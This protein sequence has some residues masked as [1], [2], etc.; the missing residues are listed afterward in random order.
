MTGGNISGDRQSLAVKPMAATL[1]SWSEYCAPVIWP[2]ARARESAS[3]GAL[4][5]SDRSFAAAA[6]PAN[7]STAIASKASSN[8]RE[9]ADK[10]MKKPL[11]L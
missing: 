1:F 11:P 7:A 8:E 10:S 4:A 6:L 5:A 3:F 2:E 9:R